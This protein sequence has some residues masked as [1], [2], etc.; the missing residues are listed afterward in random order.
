M[1]RSQLLHLLAV[2]SFALTALAL[3]GCAT[4]PTAVSVDTEFKP[5][6][7]LVAVRVVELGEVPIKRFS[8]VSEATGEVYPMRA[9]QF[10]QT[11]ATTYVG[12]LPAGRYQPKEMWGTAYDRSRAASVSVSGGAVSV[13]VPTITVTVPLASLTGKFDVQARRITDLGT[14]VFVPTSAPGSRSADGERNFSFALPLVPIAVPT[15]ALVQARFPALA[16][17]IE[18]R[19]ALS[20]V[21]G[22]VPQPPRQVLDAAR[23]RVVALTKPT[24]AVDGAMLT[25]GAMGVIDRYGRDGLTARRVWVD[26]P[27]AIEAVVVL[28]DG[29][30]L[31]GGEEGFLA[32]STDQGA[33]WQPLPRLS[34]EDVV[35]HLSQA[36]DKRIFMVVDRDREAV[37]YQ[38]LP[39]ASSTLE[40]KELR[41]LPSD[42]EQSAMTQEFGEA[43]KFLRDHVAV[44]DSRLVVYT[45]PGTLHSFDFRSGVWESNEAPFRSFHH[46]LKATPDGLV[47]GMV[48]QHWVYTTLDYGRSWTRME[49]FVHMTEPHFIDRQRGVMMAAELSMMMPGP[50]KIRTTQDGG[51]T[52]TT[53]S[54]VGG[55][56]DLM[57]PLWT[58]PSGKALYTLRMK[59]IELSKDQGQSW[60]R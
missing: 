54:Q 55:L 5:N 53:G 52:W 6:E 11:S 1:N 45:R 3:S 25:G 13:G 14:V 44:T 41:R 20:W 31:A 59:R 28:H 4:P 34:P 46:G 15:E 43:K 18:G 58:D 19:S 22:T 27:H 57:Q 35:I 2:S 21:G 16:K 36:A 50:Y 8:V 51:K 39:T 56:H 7:G 32:L 33:S 37:V 42:R 23:Q 38:A 9:I 47:I 17:A 26:T 30:W 60:M 40:W 49:S 24:F 29:R 48:A 12:R 10:G